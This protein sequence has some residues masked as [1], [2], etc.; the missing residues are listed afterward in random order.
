MRKIDYGLN[1]P[2]AIF[3]GAINLSQFGTNIGRFAELAEMG[4]T[5]TARHGRKAMNLLGLTPANA[6]S[7][8]YGNFIEEPMR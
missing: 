2:Q 5:P 1:V 6:A 8:I 3:K 7:F 4:E